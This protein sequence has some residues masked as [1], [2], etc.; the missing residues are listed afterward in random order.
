MEF[1]GVLMGKRLQASL[2]TRV[3]GL[4]GSQSRGLLGGLSGGAGCA[5]WTCW[6]RWSW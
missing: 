1:W 2:A 6:T 4:A 3:V 5:R